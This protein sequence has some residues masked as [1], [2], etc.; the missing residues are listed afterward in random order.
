MKKYFDE[1]PLTPFQARY[2]YN[3][4]DNNYPTN[5]FVE[6]MLSRKTIRRFD[7]ESPLDPKLIEKLVAVAQSAPTSSM[8]QPW[9]ILAINTKE[10]KEK[11]LTEENAIWFE[12][13]TNHL[14]KQDINGVKRSDVPTSAIIDAL[15]E[16]DTLLVWLVDFTI[17]DAVINRPDAY[18]ADPQLLKYRDQVVKLSRELDMEMRAITDTII[19]AQTFCVAAESL[20]LGVMYMGSIKNIE[21]GPDFNIPSRCIPLF[22][23]A[24]GWP[25]SDNLNTWGNFKTTPT[26]P[27]IIKPRLPQELIFHKGVYNN[28]SKERLD[29]ERFEKVKEYNQTLV[30]FY[31]WHYQSW[32]WF[33]RVIMR[34]WR[35]RNRFLDLCKN[36]GI[37]SYIEK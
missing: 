12:A 27:T 33:N 4:P 25:K 28:K 30:R 5:F 2:G 37:F 22:G 31:R 26:A 15:K 7:T 21:L 32:D 29:D 10:Q 14:T 3:V 9:S 18:D 17:T 13:P 6:K 8:L 11:L 24:I 16:C 36:H 23:M 19:A 34:T 20:G 35:K 1:V